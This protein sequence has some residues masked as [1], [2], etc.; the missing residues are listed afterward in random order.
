MNH[1]KIGLIV[2]LLAGLVLAACA[3]TT[4]EPTPLPTHT[5]LPA[6]T[7]RPTFTPTTLA[8]ATAEPT[9]KP[10]E[11]QATR[12][13]TNTPESV[14]P[15][16]TEPT[17]TPLPPTPTPP[18]LTPTPAATRAAGPPP[19]LSGTLLFPV[20]DPV[21]ETYHIYQLD[22]DSG[23]MEVFVE[24]ASQ[25]AVTLTGG[26]I[27]W[28]SWDP[29]QRGL[30]SRPLDGVDVWPMI[31]FH[32]A[33]RPAWSPSGEQFVFPSRQEPDRESRLYLFTGIGDEPFIEIQRNG[34]P[35]IGRTPA[36]LPDDRIVYQGC[37]EDD[38]GLILMNA[39]GTNPEFLQ[40]TFPDDTAPAVSP[41]PPGGGTG[42]TQIA[43]MSRGSDS[44][45]YW[46]VK[47]ANTDGSG[48]RPLTDDW[49]W[50]G[51]PAW[52]PDGQYIVFVSTRDDNW[53]D[54]FELIDNAAAKRRLWIMDA[55]G[56]NQRLL[57]DFEFRLDGVPAG[58]PGYQVEGWIAERLV[59]LP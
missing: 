43:Y 22:L 54:R 59:W 45:N 44:S 28:R 42:G 53:P 1:T 24:Q 2:L 27:A 4:P 55:D 18:A 38:C 39:D 30:L 7:L 20:F 50:N 10:T 52:S 23:E 31:T 47:I 34:S 9:A 25:P 26:R 16:P 29:E 14:A 17:A 41:A 40:N 51:L 57:N 6:A 8:R 19:K 11:A 32:E 21:G 58:V 37:V 48:Q 33:A 36:F 3:P 35:I 46:Q 15:Q 13:P 12:L 56:G 5:A 49:Y